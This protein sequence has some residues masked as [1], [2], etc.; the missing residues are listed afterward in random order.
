[1]TSLIAVGITL[2]VVIYLLLCTFLK[3][4]QHAQEPPTIAFPFPFFTPMI[5]ILKERT[6]FFLTLRYAPAPFPFSNIF[7]SFFDWVTESAKA[8]AHPIY[9]LRLLGSRV[10]VVNHLS[11]IK[12]VQR[13]TKTLSL[14]RIE[15]LIAARGICDA[16][17]ATCDILMADADSLDGNQGYTATIHKA[18]HDHLRPGPSLYAM[19]RVIL[20]SISQGMGDT[21][22]TGPLKTGLFAWITK[23][24]TLATTDA[25]YGDKNPFRNPS[26]LDLF[27]TFESSIFGLLVR[28]V[29]SITARNGYQ[30]RAVLINAFITYFLRDG[31]STGSDFTKTRFRKGNAHGI[32]LEELAKLEMGILVAILSN[33]IP[34]AFWVI[35]HI[36][37]DVD[38]LEQCREEASKLLLQKP[39]LDDIDLSNPGSQCP[40]LNS[41]LKETLR[42]HN[43]GVS[44]REVLQDHTLEGGYFLRRGSM[45]LMPSV[46]QHENTVL[47]GEDAGMF[48]HNRFMQ[49]STHPGAFRGFGG[50]STLCPG[51][52]LASF[53]VL[54]F[55]I[56]AV[57]RFDIVPSAGSWTMPTTHKAAI[58]AAMPK[59][60][61]EVDV[62]IE[63]RGN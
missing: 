2:S 26:V 59:P 42:Y 14:R 3:W 61:H 22:R 32:G 24:V 51:R 4:T 16:R 27:W 60:D 29:P 56:M 20:S 52:H 8:G 49:T 44:A 11:L 57:L 37:S 17:K 45:I 10:Y 33:T 41:V 6:R 18:M 38:V 40:I 62:I 13:Q 15:V 34:T 47:W 1:M 50:G 30:A 19:N 55:S 63:P 35:Y 48:Q 46:L 7:G 58:W 31:P 39:Y 53:E 28:L 5:G 21:A 12:A 9:T 25:V 43:I 36:Y 23:L 54:A